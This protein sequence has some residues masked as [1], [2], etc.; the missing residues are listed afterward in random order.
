MRSKEEEIDEEELQE[1][2]QGSPRRREEP[3]RVSAAQ[4]YDGLCARDG[5]VELWLP[6]GVLCLLAVGVLAYNLVFKLRTVEPCNE[7][8]MAM[9]KHFYCYNKASDPGVHKDNAEADGRH[10]F[11]SA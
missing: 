6:L 8:T 5:A 1:F 7:N 11:A 9:A 4:W 2:T 10:L 3:I